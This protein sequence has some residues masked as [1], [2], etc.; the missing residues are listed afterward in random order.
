MMIETKAM[1][2]AARR[3]KRHELRERALR[4]QE[5]YYELSS[6][7]KIGE[8]TRK[9]TFWCLTEAGPFAAFLTKV[10]IMDDD[11][12]RR[13]RLSKETASHLLFE[14]EQIPENITLPNNYTHTHFENSATNLVKLMR[15]I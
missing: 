2:R 5:Q 8:T 9:E 12:C 6:I 10:G 13:C 11:S 4:E 15:A 3:E 14:C 1:D 7:F